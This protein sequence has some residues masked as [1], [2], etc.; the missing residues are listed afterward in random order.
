MPGTPLSKLQKKA[1]NGGEQPRP[2]ERTP[3]FEGE[4]NPVPEHYDSIN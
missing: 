2:G 3:L 1:R 4:G